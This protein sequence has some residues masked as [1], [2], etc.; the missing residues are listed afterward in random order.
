LPSH[1]ICTYLIT[2]YAKDDTL[3][4]KDPYIRAQVDQGLHF[5][6]GVLFS[7]LRFLYVRKFKKIK[8]ILLENLANLAIFWNIIHQFAQV[9]LQDSKSFIRNLKILLQEPIL[10]NG[11]PDMPEDRVEYI[12]KAYGL[13][14]AVLKNHDYL[15]GNSLT[16]ADISS[17]AT[18]SSIGGVV[19]ID[20][21][22]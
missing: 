8:A 21:D 15:V 7:R 5:D 4:P 3:Y 22:K 6:S 2:K 11:S 10:Y 12:R 20:A 1:A 18:I 14:E 16:L 13:L 9:F 17:I 19:P